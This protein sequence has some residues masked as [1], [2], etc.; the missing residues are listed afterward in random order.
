MGFTCKGD[1][2]VAGIKL[3]VTDMDGTFLG[4]GGALLEANCEAFRRAAASGYHIAFASGRMATVMSQFAMEAGLPDC[5][6]IGNNGAQGFDRPFGSTLYVYPLEQQ[7][8]EQCIEIIHRHG[9]AFI[10]NTD[11][12]VYTNVTCTPENELWYRRT[13]GSG[14][15]R[16]IFDAH[17][18]AHAVG[19]PPLKLLIYNHNGE[20]AFR[21]AVEEI[22]ALPGLSLTSGT[23]DAM[24]V[25]DLKADKSLGVKALADSLG[26]DL[27]EVMA[28]GDSD[29]DAA[30]LRVCGHSVAMGNATPAAREAAVHHTLSNDDLGVAHIVNQLLDG[31]FPC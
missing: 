25:M 26:I 20:E 9:C 28:F 13:Y 24:E 22:S 6:I 14:G 16:L 21:H 15:T 17:P 19:E 27:S 1:M 18:E 3:I 31:S 4:K 30:M 23:R 7:V 12:G 11:R 10:L 5:H 2:T 8:Y 29:N